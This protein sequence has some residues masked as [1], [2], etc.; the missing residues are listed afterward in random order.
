MPAV[1]RIVLAAADN[2]SPARGGTFCRVAKREAG[3]DEPR[4]PLRAGT[5]TS[6]DEAHT[7]SVSGGRDVDVESRRL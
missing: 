7:R 3:A 4:R 1:A 5:A 2:V 6:T